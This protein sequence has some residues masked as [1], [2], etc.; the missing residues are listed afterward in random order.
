MLCNQTYIG[1][2]V[3]HTQTSKSFKNPKV[4]RV[5]EDEWIIVENMHEPLVDPETFEKARRNISIKK[6]PNNKM[7]T[8][9]FVGLLICADCGWRLSFFSHM[10][11]RGGRGGFACNNYRHNNRSGMDKRCTAHSIGYK[12][13]YE[14]ILND[15]NDVII[16]SFDEQAF[17]KRLKSGQTDNAAADRKTLEKLKHRDSELRIL[18]RKVFEQNALGAITDATFSDL[19]NTYQTEQKDVAAKSEAMEAKLSS[20]AQVKD[21]AA[22]FLEMVRK[23]T[24]VTELTRQVLLD[25]IDKIIVYE[26]TGDRKTRRQRIDIHYRFIG[27]LPGT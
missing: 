20:A 7:G 23:Y 25:F 18:A 1:H 10:T 24:E 5:P 9:I 22:R 3:S 12:L 4:V 15:I 14:A 16:S 2:I 8:N 11:V 27:Q 13:L 6:R 19:Y 26:A 21:N 17:L